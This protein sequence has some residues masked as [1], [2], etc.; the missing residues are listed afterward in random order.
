MLAAKEKALVKG[1]REQEIFMD[2][3]QSAGGAIIKP[4]FYRN[5][6][7]PVA[8]VRTDFDV[9][10]GWLLLIRDSLIYRLNRNPSVQTVSESTFRCVSV[11]GVNSYDNVIAVQKA[12][13]ECSV[14][15]CDGADD[16]Q[17]L[18]A[19]LVTG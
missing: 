3:K 2:A 18:T 10:D 6:P 1:S 9:P 7:I 14:V 17:S 4:M 5:Q 19:Q 12:S 16:R 13:G 11:N 8:C 15:E